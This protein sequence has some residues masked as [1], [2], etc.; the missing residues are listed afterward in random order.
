ME[1]LPLMNSLCSHLLSTAVA[2]ERG[3]GA[4]IIDL[5]IGWSMNNRVQLYE[6]LSGETENVMSSPYLNDIM[7]DT[8]ISESGHV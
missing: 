2:L 5:H 6:C 4:G 8:S 3:R 7:F 1:V